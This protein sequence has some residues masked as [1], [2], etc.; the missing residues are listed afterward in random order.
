MTSS[1]AVFVLLG[2]GLQLSTVFED[3][4][5]FMLLSGADSLNY[6]QAVM[7]HQVQGLEGNLHRSCTHSM[8]LGTHLHISITVTT[9]TTGSTYLED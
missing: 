8:R 2:S 7:P 4:R 3:L 1:L 9:A 6:S 5:H